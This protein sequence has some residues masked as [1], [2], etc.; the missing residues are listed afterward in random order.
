MLD[1]EVVY[2]CLTTLGLV[3]LFFVVIGIALV[4]IG[5][6]DHDPE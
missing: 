3:V 1:V 2:A 5:D 6:G 4:L